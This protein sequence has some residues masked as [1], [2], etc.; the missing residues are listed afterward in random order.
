MEKVELSYL[1]ELLDFDLKSSDSTLFITSRNYSDTE[2]YFEERL[3]LEVAKNLNC[4]AIFFRRFAEKQSSIPQIFIFDNTSNQ[5]SEEDLAIIHRKIWSSSIVPLY[6]VFDNLNFKVYDA[7]KAVDYNRHD[8]KISISA[9]EILP[10]IKDSFSQFRKY[11]AKLFQNGTFWEQKEVSTHFLSKESAQNKLIEGLKRVRSQF[12]EESKLPNNLAHQILVLSIL[13]KYLEERKDE[14]GNHVFPT[15]YFEKYTDSSS[16]CDVIRSGN[17]V[18]L[19]EDLSLHFNGKIFE[20]ADEEKSILNRT[21]LSILAD[22]LDANVENNQYLIWPQYSFEYLPVE[23]ISRIYEEFIPERSDA[24]YTP[25]HL[26]RLMV[27][28]C[29]PISEPKAYFKVIDVSCGSGVFLVTVFKRLVQWWQKEQFD[30]TGLIVHPTVDILKKILRDSVFGVDIEVDSV[31]LSVF[32][33]SIALCDML[34]PTEIWTKL[35]FEDLKEKNIYTGD[36]FKYLN[37]TEKNQFD[38]VIGNPPFKKYTSK[39]FENLLETYN[40]FTECKIHGNQIALLFLQKAMLLLKR[41]G[42]LAL[43]MPSSSL[44]YGNTLHYREWLFSHYNVPQIID[45]TNLSSILFDKANV[46]TAVTFVDNKLPDNDNIL[47]ITIKRTKSVKEN[48][49]FEID[50]YDILPVP[51]EIAKTESYVWK[52]NLLGGTMLLQTLKSFDNKRQL[53]EFLKFKREKS[54]WFFGEGYKRNST[55]KQFSDDDRAGYL[56]G[57]LMVPTNLFDEYGI[58]GT[59]IETSEY[60]ESPRKENQKIFK[61]PHV[62]FKNALGKKTLPLHYLDEDMGFMREIVGIYSP[63]QDKDELIKLVNTIRNNSD[64]YRF[65]LIAKSGRAGV[66]RSIYTLKTE[67]LLSLPFPDDL[68]DLS[69]SRNE[70]ILYSDI[71]QYKLEELSKGENAKINTTAVSNKQLVEF[72]AVFCE[73]LNS[74]YQVD[75]RKFKPLSPIH[76]ISYTCFPFAYGDDYFIPEISSKI[77]EGDLSELI[78]NRQD[79]VHYRRILRLYQKDLVFLVKP[80]SFRFWLKSIALR[81]ASDVMIDLVNSGY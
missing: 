21:D 14:Q 57:K 35:R 16:F 65:I 52:T 70:I 11:S 26:A 38:L 77:K 48:L 71:I 40:L 45:C 44:L 81:D 46:A 23:L 63:E 15:D 67:D 8:K 64:L 6:Y 25:I 61:A 53:G 1:F 27:D 58:K 34:K 54:G 42:L 80:N 76:T 17:I 31:R 22:Y 12:I 18:N 5:F 50:Y 33:L 75:G 9:I 37:E 79:S 32:S 47:H 62:L 20:L 55:V 10:L 51:K 39:N 7:R 66:D 2:I 43:I 13:V 30:K 49:F 72:G 24:V 41:N 29:M 74:I 69:L 68:E 28:E 4:T 19:F 60:F 3:V 36:F 59:K 56:T 78:E 73:N